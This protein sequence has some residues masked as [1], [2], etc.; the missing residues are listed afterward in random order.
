[1]IQYDSNLCQVFFPIPL[2]LL[3][4]LRI[5]LINAEEDIAVVAQEF[6]R[7]PCLVIMIDYERLGLFGVWI[8]Y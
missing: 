8:D 5:F 2:N 6:S 1:M 7:L 3:E 4:P